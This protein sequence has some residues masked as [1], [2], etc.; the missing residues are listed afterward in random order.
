MWRE[1]FCVWD[2]EQAHV[3]LQI[4]TGWLQLNLVWRNQTEIRFFFL[5]THK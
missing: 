3:A 1:V 2:D 4:G 5:H